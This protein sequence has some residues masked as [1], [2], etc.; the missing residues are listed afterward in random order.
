[1]PM[2]FDSV[3]AWLSPTMGSLVLD[4]GSLGFAIFVY[5]L[6]CLLVVCGGVDVVAG[7]RFERGPG[8]CHS[9]ME[10]WDLSL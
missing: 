8:E 7:L 1:M 2:R 4:L 3:F 6:C 5:F 10:A 9:K